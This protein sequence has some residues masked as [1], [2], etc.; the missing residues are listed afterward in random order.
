M[1]RRPP[2]STR[3]DT[4]FP[5]T[6]L[7]RSLPSLADIMSGRI[8]ITAIR[9]VT[10]EELLSRDAVTPDFN[11]IAGELTGRSVLVTGGGG[12]I[13][14]ALCREILRHKPRKLVV[15]DAS[16]H[17]LY[18]IDEDLIERVRD[19]DSEIGRAACGERVCPY[20]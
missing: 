5:Y 20:V 12:S 18:A 17:A 9:D 16:E 7:F 3:T 2:R 8:A 6:T 19:A 1:I 15:L 10:A 13:G 11:L 4:L 14:S